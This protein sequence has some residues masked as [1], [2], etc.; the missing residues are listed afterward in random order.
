MSDSLSVLLPMRAGSE[1]VPHK[2]TKAFAGFRFG[3]A[4]LKIKQLLRVS[5]VS[6]ILI[7]TDEESITDLIGSLD[8][9]EEERS[10]IRVEK[11][12][13][14][15]AGSDVTTDSLIPYLAEKVVSEHIL[16]T[17]V[18]SPFLGSSC[19][20]DAIDLYQGFVSDSYDSLMSVSSLREFIWDTDGPQNY[21]RSRE[22][23][24]RTQTLPKWYF[25]NS[26]IFLC[27]RLFYFSFGDRIGK[28]PYLLEI[29]KITGFDVD[30]PIDFEIAE[31]IALQRKDLVK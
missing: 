9:N 18:T 30:W 2:N 24:P 16:W 15:Y 8:L 26:G 3:L 28:K 22:L 27:P 4:E 14:K 6:E 23:W 13:P 21:D 20:Q 11:R 12:D 31:H 5:G 29:D 17:H 25:V 7:D 19:Y 10:I 1:R